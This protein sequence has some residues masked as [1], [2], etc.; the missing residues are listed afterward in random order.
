MSFYILTFESDCGKFN[1][2]FRL[3]WKYSIAL[4]TLE[5]FIVEITI[6]VYVYAD[7]HLF[8]NYIRNTGMSST[9]MYG[10]NNLVLSGKTF[11]N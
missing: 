7:F 1:L 6:F 2:F 4:N 11:M 8:D 10:R 9:S 5:Y 3:L